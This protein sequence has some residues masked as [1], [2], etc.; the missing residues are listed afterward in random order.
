MSR[1][2]AQIL[3]AKFLRRGGP[4]AFTCLFEQAAPALREAV[5][6]RAAL[7]EGEE[8]VI[9]GAPSPDRWVLL[10]SA[11]V[12]SLVEGELRSTD[13]ADVEATSLAPRGFRLRP[14]DQLDLIELTTRGGGRVLLRVEPGGAFFGVLNALGSA[15]QVSARRR[16]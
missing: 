7:R 2:V 1:L 13:Y 9:L 12:L 5:T 15:V 3:R 14:K 4:G 16:A 8:P 10:T 11:R 6:A